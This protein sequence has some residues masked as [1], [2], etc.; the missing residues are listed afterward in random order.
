MENEGIRVFE[1]EYQKRMEER[2]K[3]AKAFGG[4]KPYKR[5][6]GWRTVMK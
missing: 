3:T 2:E 4:V 5:G 6:G 1:D